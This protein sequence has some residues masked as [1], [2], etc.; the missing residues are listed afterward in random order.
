MTT[1]DLWKLFRSNERDETVR[2]ALKDREHELAVY[3]NGGEETPP[4]EDESMP[5]RDAL[6]E[7]RINLGQP[8]FA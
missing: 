4:H 6:L 1:P 8:Y 7:L 5:D 3:A 2:S